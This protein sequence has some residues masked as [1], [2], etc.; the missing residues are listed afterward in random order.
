ML[1]ILLT[2]YFLH[3]IILYSAAEKNKTRKHA[4]E[5]LMFELPHDE[6][7]CG[8]GIHGEAGHE[9]IKLKT[10]SELVAL[11]LKRICEVLRLAAGDAVAVIVN[12]F[13]ALSKLEEGIVVHEV[14]SQLR[15]CMPSPLSLLYYYHRYID[16]CVRASMCVHVYVWQVVCLILF[17][18][19]NI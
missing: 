3:R 2:D 8:M 6:V 7:E 4:G 17:K 12:N 1:R 14:V 13:G 10:A 18:R 16:T 11:M 15:K 5:G 19:C 9:R